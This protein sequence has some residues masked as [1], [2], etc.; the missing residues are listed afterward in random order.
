MAKLIPTMTGVTQPPP[1]ATG[2]TSMSKRSYPLL[3]SFSENVVCSGFVAH[4]SASG[5]ALATEESDGWWFYGLN[6]G[7]LAAQGATLRE[8]HYAFREEFRKVLFDIAVSANDFAHFRVEVERFFNESEDGTLQE[9]NDAVQAVRSGEIK[10]DNLPRA[11]ADERPNITV[12][13]IR[14][15]QPSAN[16]TV[17]GSPAVAA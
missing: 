3:C 7:A 8:A 9:W 15:L 5:R 4:V 2:S 12:S 16:G 1:P 17:E 6:P 14:N 10:L 13:L 11:S